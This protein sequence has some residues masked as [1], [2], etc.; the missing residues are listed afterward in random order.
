L[1]KNGDTLALA[2]EAAS[3]DERRLATVMSTNLVGHTALTQ[4][5]NRWLEIL[6]KQERKRLE[7]AAEIFRRL[8]GKTRHR[9]SPS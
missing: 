5:N 2:K 3:K 4:E 9:E 7:H 1:P 6:D 8:G